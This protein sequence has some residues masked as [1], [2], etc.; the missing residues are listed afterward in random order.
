MDRRTRPLAVVRQY[1]CIWSGE[2]EVLRIAEET[3]RQAR[4]RPSR[5]RASGAMSP[6]AGCTK[7]RGLS[8][9]QHGPDRVGESSGCHRRKRGR[10]E[11]RSNHA[12]G[13]EGTGRHD[14]RGEEVGRLAQ[15]V[16]AI[17]ET[18][19]GDRSANGQLRIRKLRMSNGFY[20]CYAVVAYPHMPLPLTSSPV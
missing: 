13:T 17:H 18:R 12:S 11:A 3:T 7:L 14:S 8:S 5:R 10:L 6:T 1:T 20:T 16:G 15:D 2:T 19:H 9:P 4:L